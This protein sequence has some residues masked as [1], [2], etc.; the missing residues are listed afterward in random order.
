MDG[1]HLTCFYRTCLSFERQ[2]LTS[3]LASLH[4]NQHWG[5]YSFFSRWRIWESQSICTLSRSR[6]N[7]VDPFGLIQFT[8]ENIFSPFFL[9]VWDVLGLLASRHRINKIY[10]TDTERNK[11][12]RKLNRLPFSVRCVILLQSCTEFLFLKGIS[13]KYPGYLR[14]LE[15]KS[16]CCIYINVLFT[17][18]LKQNCRP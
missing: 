14:S 4:G 3:C 1:Q 9:V 11:G 2:L 6:R 10:R 13:S 18:Y 12:L 8:T 15:G 17:T 5:I 7:P 16:E